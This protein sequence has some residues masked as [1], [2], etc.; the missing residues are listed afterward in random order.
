MCIYV[1]RNS[2]T[3]SFS[4]FISGTKSRSARENRQFTSLYSRI[5]TL[6]LTLFKNFYTFSHFI[7][8]FLHFF[9]FYSRIS[10]LFLILFQEQEQRAEVLILSLTHSLTLTLSPISSHPFITHSLTHSSRILLSFTHIHTYIHRYLHTYIHRNKEQKYKRESI[11]Y[12]KKTN[13]TRRLL[14]MYVCMYVHMYVCMSVCM[15]FYVCGCTIY[16]CMCLFLSLSLALTLCLSLSLTL[17]FFLS[18][19]VS[20]SVSVCLTLSFSLFSLCLCLCLSLSLFSVCR[21]D[22]FSRKGAKKHR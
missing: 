14:C 1:D 21:L 18:V 7:Q 13:K 11:I 9:S 12:A 20:V 19:F 6:F 22:S 8:E 16:V 5:S 15:F 2:I 10:T 4:H 17:S 3:H